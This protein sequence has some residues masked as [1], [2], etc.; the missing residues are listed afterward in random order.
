MWNLDNIWLQENKLSGWQMSCEAR[1]KIIFFLDK[2]IKYP[3]WSQEL[4]NIYE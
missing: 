4:K 1:R 3:N 2:Y